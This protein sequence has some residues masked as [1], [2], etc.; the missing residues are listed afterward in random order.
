MQE[1]HRVVAKSTE[2]LIGLGQSKRLAAMRKSQQAHKVNTPSPV[3]QRPANNKR[4]A[5]IKQARELIT[6]K[7]AKIKSNYPQGMQSRLFALRYGAEEKIQQMT[8]QKLF[9]VLNI[10][11]V[12]T[13][14]IAQLKFQVQN[15]TGGQLWLA[16]IEHG[17]SSV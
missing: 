2:S 17:G 12:L 15:G 16:T 6:H 11:Q 13:K 14:E 9:T 8:L 5:E 1:K 4:E 10:D 7:I 3:I